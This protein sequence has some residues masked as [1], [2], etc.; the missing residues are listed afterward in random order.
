MLNINSMFSGMEAINFQTYSQL[1]KDLTETFQEVI[2]FRNDLIKKNDG[3]KTYNANRKYR[4][5]KVCDFCRKNMAPKF[6]SAVEKNLGLEVK[7]LHMI[8]IAEAINIPQD[9]IPFGP[10]FKYGVEINISEFGNDYVNQQLRMTGTNFRDNIYSGEFEKDV[11]DLANCIDLK[12]GKI[13]RDRTRPNNIKIYVSRM[14]FDVLASFCITDFAD[15]DFVEPFTA[16]ELA[17]IMM[18]EC[19]HAMSVIE[20][21]A[22]SYVTSSRLCNYCTTISRANNAKDLSKMTKSVRT[23]LIPAMKK[24]AKGDAELVK[25]VNDADKRLANIDTILGY[26]SKESPGEGTLIGGL[27]VLIW[28]VIMVHA[29]IAYLSLRYVIITL[30]RAVYGRELE[31]YLFHF[32]DSTV[33]NVKSNDRRDNYNQQF[34]MERWADEFVARHGYGDHLASGLRKLVNA[35]KYCASSTGKLLMYYRPLNDITIYSSLME[36]YISVLWWMY[37]SSWLDPIKYEND[38]DRT[39]RIL[40]NTKSVFKEEKLPDNCV[41]EWVSKCNEIE[42]QMKK[43]K[44]LQHTDFG[45][46]VVNVLHNL[47]M[48]PSNLFQ[49]IKDG[50]MD[51]DCAILEDRLD[52]MRN[53]ALFMMSHI[54]RTM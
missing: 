7:T 21:A 1:G 45:R 4:I 6:I 10:D 9:I 31:R 14:Y 35:I 39:K 42:L 20:H 3:P 23:N 11:K 34:I 2:D 25:Q 18:H 53:N 24:A 41:Y 33:R 22:D 8:N 44:E 47:I 12:S 30:V 37:P 52:D 17:A 43:I 13:V 19:G 50:K 5:L 48:D 40:Q 26:A 46:G 28:N 36:A 16:E 15:P 27:S 49:L 29:R 32:Y 54:F 38:F 51:R